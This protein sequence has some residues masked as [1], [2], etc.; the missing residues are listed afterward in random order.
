MSRLDDDPQVAQ[1]GRELGLSGPD[2]WLQQIQQHALGRVRK[3]LDKAPVSVSSLSGLLLFLAERLNVKIEYLRSDHD[4]ERISREYRFSK[5]GSK[6]LC[7]DLNDP[8]TDGLLIHNPD[9]RPGSR[10]YLAV[11]DARR[12]NRSRAYFT[13]WHEL[14]HL[15]VTPPQRVFE[16]VYRTISATRDKDPEE[17]VVDAVAGMLAFYEPF[18][19][20]ALETS[21]AAHTHRFCLR[22]V[23]DVRQEAASDASFQSTAIACVRLTDHPAIFLEVRQGYKEDEKRR[24]VAAASQCQLDL[25]S[26]PEP[27]APKLRATSVIR[28]ASASSS[29]L[30][31]FR[32]MRIPERSILDKAYRA[33]HDVQFEAVEDQAWWSTSDGRQRRKLDIRVEAIRKG[34]YV[35]GLVSPA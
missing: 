3:L 12:V 5:I 23:E 22:V 11:V 28:S 30:R 4:L 6:R 1:L 35:Y 9:R 7:L 24:L 29:G 14:T 2:N 32:N 18:I 17:S 15:I 20:P 33:E 13:A 27:L 26:P 25:G 31:I 19:R 8:N 21:E 16:G 10:H 34:P